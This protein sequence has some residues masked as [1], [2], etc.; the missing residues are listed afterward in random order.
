[1]ITMAC[2]RMNGLKDALVKSVGELYARTEDDLYVIVPKQLTLDTENLLNEGLQLS[3]SFRI[4][5]LSPDRLCTAI[6]NEA[7]SPAGASLDERGR[8]MLTHRVLRRTGPRLKVYRDAWKKRGFAE[9]AAKELE[10][11]VESSLTGDMLREYAADCRG[12]LAAKLNDLALLTEEYREACEGKY[13]DGT[14]RFLQAAARV[15]DTSLVNGTSFWF[16]GFES[17]P[18]ALT[19]LIVRLGRLVKNVTVYFAEDPSFDAPDSEVFLP[20]RSARERLMREAGRE[21]VDLRLAA[22][23]ET[24]HPGRFSHAEKLLFSRNIPGVTPCPEGLTGAVLRDMTTE[25]RYA[26]SY[27][28]RLAAEN[29]WHWRDFLILLQDP[30]SYN[31]LLA[32]AFRTAGIPLTLS[33]SSPASGNRLASHLLLALDICARGWRPDDLQEYLLSGFN[34]LTRDEIER[35]S[36]Y[37]VLSGIKGARFTRPL[38]DEAAES[39][40]LRVYEPVSRLGDRLKAGETL[41]AQ[42][43]AIYDFLTETDCP[44]ESER[45][46]DELRANGQGRLA[47]ELSQVWNRIMGSLDQL[48]ALLGPD[49]LPVVE[50]SRLLRDSLDA[51]EIKTLPE[52]YDS[53]LAQPLGRPVSG[54][55]RAVLMLGM[56]DS[57]TRGTDLLM[58]QEQHLS[59]ARR[60]DTYLCP[61]PE[62]EPLLRRCH[63]KNAVG[64]AGDVLMFSYAMSNGTSV[65]QPGPVFDALRLLYGDS[66]V[67]RGGR[68]GDPDIER[69]MLSVPE[70]ALLLMARGIG[71]RLDLP[72]DD[73]TA[74]MP[75]RAADVRL[76]SRMRDPRAE[77][78]KLTPAHV[79]E[80]YNGLKRLSV[81]RLETYAKCPFQYFMQYGIKPVIV[82]SPDFTVMD[83]GT[84]LHDC[85]SEFCHAHSGE[86]SNMT[87]ER[88]RE[89]MLPIARE[90][91]VGLIDASRDPVAAARADGL[92][93]NA[94]NAAEMIARHMKD[95]LFRVKCTEQSFGRGTNENVT[96]DGGACTLE[97][98]IDRIDEWIDSDK[99]GFVRVIDYKRSGREPDLNGIYYGTQLQLLMYLDSAMKSERADSAGVYYFNLGDGVISTD[100]RD[101]TAIE[102]ARVKL[103]A[104]KGL[105]PANE[106]LLEAMTPD[107]TMLGLS[108]RT[109]P[110]SLLSPEDYG[111]LIAHANRMA[112][113]HLRAIRGGDASVAPL[114]E[115]GAGS[116]FGGTDA[117]RYCDYADACL[118]DASIANTAR[119]NEKLNSDEVKMRLIGE[120]TEIVRERL[121]GAPESE[122]K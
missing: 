13:I 100:D 81:S 12:I 46:C 88:A 38:R 67:I 7:G 8:A 16:Y 60:T 70:E 117:C 24:E 33:D 61:A 37:I 77:A 50:L 105:A 110:E 75:D 41:S 118:F 52:S 11:L 68:T 98:R 80:L 99:K 114:K 39:L 103:Y 30:A 116:D 28:R 94:G 86:L 56:C 25:A 69:T 1:M 48:N 108:S 27:V 42:L 57:P 4:Q 115:E 58:T 35:F 23:P 122:E 54:S 9:R 14:E 102:K 107:R 64:I 113:E 95:S 32:S 91:L 34:A 18:P 74:A 76:L 15:A 5:V 20:I 84:Y 112:C 49:R 71:D 87:P 40:R 44:G 109:K 104:M 55:R 19:R 106:E 73:M 26:A 72:Y 53:V 51:V 89:A 31:P 47:N 10:L 78:D 101:E 111:R 62:E 90:K 93:E 21:Q 3:G 36:N 63:I 82:E 45:I 119:V 29:G 97:G 121:A 66:F 92:T 79:E 120:E 65:N 6:F 85:V 2:G 59:L 17:T 96:L 83:E 43:T 22:L